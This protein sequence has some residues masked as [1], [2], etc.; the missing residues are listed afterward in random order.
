MIRRRRA[1][2]AARPAGP[3]PDPPFQ[4]LV[5]ARPPDES[6]PDDE[7]PVLCVEDTLPEALQM[8][9]ET[10]GALIQETRLTDRTIAGV[11]EYEHVRYIYPERQDP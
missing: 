7:P 5:L 9:V 4:Y 11:P 6:D 1:R 3:P 10:S 8:L 2:G